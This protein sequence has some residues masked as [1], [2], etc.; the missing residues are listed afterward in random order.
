MRTLP[1]MLSLL[2]A[3][4]LAACAERAPQPAP[5]AQASGAPR[6]VALS[7]AVAVTLRDLG[8]ADR[9][10]GRHAWD[11]VLDRSLPVCG[12]Q[13]G[14]NYESLLAAR[15]THVI[16]EWGARD[17]PARLVDLADANGW[18]VRTVRLLSL[19]DIRAFAA[20]AADE[21]APGDPR[22]AEVVSSLDRI[23]D[24]VDRIGAGRV[25]L[26]LS[27]SP[28]AA[29]GPGSYHH[30]ILVLLGGAPA[31]AQGQ[32]YISLNAEDVLRLAPD[33]IVLIAPRSPGAPDAGEPTWDEIAARLGRL[34]ELP[35]PA[36]E[37]RRVAVIDDPL[38]LI[39]ST[40][41]V[42]FAERLRAILDAWNEPRP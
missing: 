11:L 24:G 30:E 21:F 42:A 23:A 33:G 22:A 12:D 38:A 29:L 26:L 9:I 34:A 20:D 39:P 1:A 18:S 19:A 25:L 2:A 6:I 41:A 8:L 27:A 16:L 37:R 31:L 14:I 10:V 28:S 13:S 4:L 5:P 7:P 35:I 40:A 32:P 36:V 3:A 15:P 17:L